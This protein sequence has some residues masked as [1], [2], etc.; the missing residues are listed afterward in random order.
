MTQRSNGVREL[1]LTNLL[2]GAATT[3]EMAA[4][5]GQP[6]WRVANAVHY[7]HRKGRIYREPYP[8]KGA[9]RQFLYSLEPF[10]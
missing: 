9:A 8:M 4:S 7:L 6:V 1:V 2:G 10:S 5:I 3:A